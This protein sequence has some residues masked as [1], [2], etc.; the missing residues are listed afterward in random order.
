MP[1]EIIN[2]YGFVSL[3]EMFRVLHAPQSFEALHNAKER[4]YFTK[5]L[6]RQLNAQLTKQSL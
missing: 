6:Q 1:A 2:Q 3:Q 4:I 5:L